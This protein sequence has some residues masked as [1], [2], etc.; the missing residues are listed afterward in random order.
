MSIRELIEELEYYAENCGDDVKV[1]I[2]YRDGGGHYCG[3][4]DPEPFYFGG[5]LEL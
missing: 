3:H 1:I 4:G 5:V 2:P